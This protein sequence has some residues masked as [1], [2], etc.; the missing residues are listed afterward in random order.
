MLASPSGQETDPVQGGVDDSRDVIAGREF[1]SMTW[2]SSSPF[3][4]TPDPFLDYPTAE[5][6]I[7]GIPIAPMTT[8]QNKADE[9]QLPPGL[10]PQHSDHTISQGAF[11][12]LA[13]LAPGGNMP[14]SIPFR[15]PGSNSFSLLDS[16]PIFPLVPPPLPAGSSNRQRSLSE[17]SVSSWEDS[18]GSSSEEYRTST[19]QKSKESTIGDLAPPQHHHQQQSSSSSMLLQNGSMPTGT[20]PL[21]CYPWDCPISSAASG[22]LAPLLSSSEHDLVQQ[23]ALLQQQAW[24]L[25]QLHATSEIFRNYDIGARQQ[26][27]QQEQQEQQQQQ[28]QEQQ[29]RDAHRRRQAAPTTRAAV[30]STGRKE[31]AGRKTSGSSNQRRKDSGATLSGRVVSLALGG[32][33]SRLLQ[34]HLSSGNARPDEIRSFVEESLP[35]IRELATDRYG[36]YFIQQLCHHADPSDVCRFLKELI[37]CPDFLKVAQDVA[38]SKVLLEITRQLKYAKHDPPKELVEVAAEMMAKMAELLGD[39]SCLS[40]VEAVVEVLPAGDCLNRLIDS[41]TT[42]S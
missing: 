6:T 13:E 34:D 42:T 7:R 16:P 35:K 19:L 41:I 39:T 2:R 22:G 11:P 12:G 8:D 40:T 36:N 21:T 24:I 4:P 25:G 29:H 14:D 15:A 3:A 20:S 1:S 5:G 26:Q 31:V 32:A 10:F 23:L 9:A 28:Q 38:G 37:S 30:K 27:Q 17:S 33:G 18:S